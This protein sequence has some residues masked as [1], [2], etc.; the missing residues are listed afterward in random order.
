M[1][2][3]SH[4]LLLR[5]GFV[6]RICELKSVKTIQSREVALQRRSRW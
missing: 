6:V 4:L 3:Y 2:M 1:K 5:N